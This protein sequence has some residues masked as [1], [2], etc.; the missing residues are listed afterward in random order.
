MKVKSYRVVVAFLVLLSIVNSPLFFAANA[1]PNGHS[2][3][4]TD[5]ASQTKTFIGYYRSIQ[6]NPKQKMIMDEALGSI[7]APCC[8]SFSARTCC[9]PCNFA[10]SLWG[11]SNY[12]IAKK[13]Y[14]VA[15][16]RTAA[17]EWINFTHPSG[18]AGDACQKGRCQL[19]TTK[20]GC[21]GMNENNLVF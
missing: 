21:G 17:S 14:N 10:K 16:V 13:H 9:C 1:T 11:L 6:L 5:I 19:P 2:L 7:P 3:T 12:L 8:K 20:D 18:Y 4:F 15:Q